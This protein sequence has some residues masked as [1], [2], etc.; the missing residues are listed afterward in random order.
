MLK[1]LHLP[2]LTCQLLLILLLAPLPKTKY[3]PVFNVEEMPQSAPNGDFERETYM[4]FSTGGLK[5]WC[6]HLAESG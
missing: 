2:C 4:A 6:C 3:S 5:G 1:L